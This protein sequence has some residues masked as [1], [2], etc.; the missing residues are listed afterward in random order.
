MA[1]SR[2][3]RLEGRSALDFLKT[4]MRNSRSLFAGA[5]C[6]RAGMKSVSLVF[7]SRSAQEAAGAWRSRMDA[8]IYSIDP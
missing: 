4:E 2:F 5:P 6:G 8:L 1:S 3:E 7:W